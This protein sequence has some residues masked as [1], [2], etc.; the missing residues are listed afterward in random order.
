ML[1]PSMLAARLAVVASDRTAIAVS[2]QA[3]L[4]GSAA[5]C[6][7]TLKLCVMFTLPGHCRRR[8]HQLWGECLSLLVGR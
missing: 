5:A 2:L 3:E 1:A 7:P 8:Q 6:S 4:A